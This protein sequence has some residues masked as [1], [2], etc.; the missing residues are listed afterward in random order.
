MINFRE[1]RLPKLTLRY[2]GIFDWDGLYAAIVDWG[3]MYGYK[4][5]EK[6]FKH[7]VPSSEGAEEEIEWVLETKA[8][9]YIKYRIEL[10]VHTWDM[11]DVDI[12][13][14][15]NKRKLTNTR[16]YII[17]EPIIEYDWQLRFEGSPFLRKLGQLYNKLTGSIEQVHWDTL[18]YRT[19]NLHAMMKKYF[20]MQ[21]K[22]HPYKKYLGED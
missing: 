5:T 22:K 3:K 13:V 12:E 7:K 19:W 6:A 18:Y 20:D 10:N 15:G 11:I 9:E 21:S 2:N 4:W 17:F 16:L 1:I 14:N 8:T